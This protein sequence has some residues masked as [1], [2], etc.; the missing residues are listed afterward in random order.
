[1]RSLRDMPF[2]TP[3]HA[4]LCEQLPLG[5]GIAHFG[6]DRPQ[7]RAMRLRQAGLAAE[8]HHIPVVLPTLKLPRIDHLTPLGP[9]EVR[10]ERVIPDLGRC[11][12]DQRP[13]LTLGNQGRSPE[14]RL[15]KAPADA[16]HRVHFQ[17]LGDAG[18]IVD[19]APKPHA[20]RVRERVR[21]GGEQDAGVGMRAGE[22]N[23]AAERHDSLSGAGRA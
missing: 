6:E 19:Q 2:Q 3:E 23:G 15:V 17:P 22:M 7:H 13:H 10:A 4:G 12:V 11:P 14:V 5:Q 18:L 9:Q 8:P 21:E 1:M 20:Q 16:A